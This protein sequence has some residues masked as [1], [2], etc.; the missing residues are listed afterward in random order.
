MSAAE[1]AFVLGT[2][3][4]PPARRARSTSA[5]RTP[6]AAVRA[7]CHRWLLPVT[8][9]LHLAAIAWLV[10]ADRAPASP[11]AE[12]AVIDVV[13]VAPPAP[14]PVATPR[15]E[16]PPA[17]PEPAQPV[18]IE[19]PPVIETPKPRP[20]RRPRPVAARPSPPAPV[21]QPALDIPQLDLPA[22]A[23]SDFA[24]T[25]PA[26]AAPAPAAPPPP[27]PQRI[28]ARYDADYL[29]NPR[30]SYPS[31]ARRL[32]E[33]GTVLLRVL[34]TPGGEPAQVRLLRSAGS[35]RLDR[36]A[37][38]AVEQWRFAPAREGDEAVAS[39]VQVPIAFTLE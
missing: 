3:A 25:A 38:A 18:E 27:L 16:A 6:P 34:V 5:R 21:P 12:D 31:L 29:S 10:S 22:P 19:A 17:P 13:F 28:E 36:A 11:A 7:T 24:P 35:P 32:G 9:L 1:L 26:V 8:T 2:D 33:Q 23:P 4:P 20:K 37:I 14:E 15:V 30:P 39:W